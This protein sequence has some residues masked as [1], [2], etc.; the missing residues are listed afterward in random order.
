M[1]AAFSIY[2][3][4]AAV[5]ANTYLYLAQ[6][7]IRAIIMAIQIKERIDIRAN[8]RIIFT[9]VYQFCFTSV[10]LFNQ[11]YLRANTD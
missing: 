7:F 10:H 8:S 1:L 2:V 3:M 9:T 6:I 4:I 11:R 5:S